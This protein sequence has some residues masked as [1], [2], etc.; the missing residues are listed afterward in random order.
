MYT[1]CFYFLAIINNA[2]LKSEYKFLCEQMI[3]IFLSP[4]NILF[5]YFFPLTF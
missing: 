5:I 1:G 3:S 4:I 2:A